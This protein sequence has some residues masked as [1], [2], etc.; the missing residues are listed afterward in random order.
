MRDLFP[1]QFRTVK[2]NGEQIAQVRQAYLPDFIENREPLM[3]Y[4]QSRAHSE[5]LNA[6]EDNDDDD[7]VRVAA[8]KK[9]SE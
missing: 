7:A 5:V 2:K 1:I 8:L 3:N 6:L 4:Y 9:L